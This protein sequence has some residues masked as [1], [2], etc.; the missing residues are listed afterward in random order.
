MGHDR[1]TTPE[2]IE[3][4]ETTMSDTKIPDDAK[5]PA[6]EKHPGSAN[7]ADPH[8]GHEDWAPGPADRWFTAT[9]LIDWGYRHEALTRLFGPSVEGPGGIQ[10]WLIDHVQH[11]EEAVINRAAEL[12]ESTFRPARLR[13]MFPALP[14]TDLGP[15]AAEVAAMVENLPPAMTT[16]VTR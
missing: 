4:G 9:E 3:L 11:I 10:G 8:N 15:S 7:E 14:D 13:V 5:D 16:K 2:A 12:L 1:N 6:R